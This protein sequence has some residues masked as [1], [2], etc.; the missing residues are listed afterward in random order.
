MAKTP[1]KSTKKHRI[2]LSKRGIIVIACALALILITILGAVVW[3]QYEFRF[4]TAIVRDGSIKVTRD[5]DF[6]ALSRALL[7]SGY[8]DN[9]ERWAAMARS[10]D[11]D[12]TQGGYYTLTEGMSYRRALNNF[13]HGRQ[14]P[15]RL[16]FNNIRSMERLAGVVSKYIEADSLEVLGTLRSDTLIAGMGFTP[17]TFPAMFIPNTYEIYWNTTPAEFAR[18][19]NREWRKFWND[20]RREAADTLD[21]TPEQISTIASIVIEETKFRGEMTNVAGVYLNRL[22]LG[23]PLQAD[24]TVKFAMGDPGIRRVLKRYLDYD[25]PYNTYKYAGLPPGP[26]CVPPIDAIDAVLAY[27]DAGHDFLYFC[28]KADFSGQHAFARSLS[29]H[30]RNAAAYS[31]ELNRRGIR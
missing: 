2:R 3:K 9:A 22:R 10:H 29:E 23:M 1:K 19:M 12:S 24:P 17:V 28:A 15:V 31:R 5:M 7:D 13:Y 4:G 27:V 20:D 18:R 6:D 25:S 21:Y 14:T 8:I 11:L 30:N 16:T 26:I